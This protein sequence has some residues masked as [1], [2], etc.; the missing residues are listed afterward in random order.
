MIWE[1]SGLE[2]SCPNLDT[3]NLS[4]NN[5]SKIENL[6]GLNV[7]STLQLANNR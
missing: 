3:L 2:D 1:I 5:I 7:L 6:G 4:S